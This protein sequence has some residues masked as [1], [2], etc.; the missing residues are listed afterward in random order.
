[1]N[2]FQKL[3]SLFKKENE[4]SPAFRRKMA[5]KIDGRH[6]KY[7]TKRVDGTE[8]VIGREGH[9][10]ILPC[11]DEIGVVCGI[12]TKFRGK[13]DETSIWELLSLEGAVIT[14]VNLETGEELSITAYY[15]YYR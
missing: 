5:E 1:M 14:G 12:D 2:I 8:E 11:G 7:V 3:V 6:I 10:N 9:V 4:T 13:I 15:K